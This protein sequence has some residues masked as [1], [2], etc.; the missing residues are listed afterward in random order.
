MRSDR[1]I[2][3]P[4]SASVLPFLRLSAVCLLPSLTMP[5]VK[6]DVLGALIAVAVV[7]AICYGLATAKPDFL[8]TKPKPF[9]AGLGKQ[10]TDKVVMRVNGDPITETEFAASFSQLPEEMQRQFASVQGKE[11]FAEQL[12]RLKILEQEGH[13][14]GVEHDPRVAGALAADRTNIIAS[15]AAQKLVPVPTEDAVI[16]FYAQN[17]G[18]FNALNLSHILIAYQGGSI[19]PKK[20]GPAPSEQEAVNRALQVY[21]KLRGGADFKA[22]ARQVSDETASAAKG[23]DLGPFS[24]GMLPPDIEGQVFRLH[25]GE[26]S[27]PIPSSFGIHIFKVNGTAPVPLDRVRNVISRRVQ[28]QNTLDRVELLRKTAKVEFDPTTFPGKA[29]PVVRKKP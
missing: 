6:R 15:A 16:R 14:M 8:P 24:Q 5:A 3:P 9:V 29:K 25:P 18:R 20:G 27:G 19:P 1:H 21:Q 2:C 23:G 12:I 11:A 28:Q 13:R 22:L 4:S 17:Q 7:G 26:I 10:N